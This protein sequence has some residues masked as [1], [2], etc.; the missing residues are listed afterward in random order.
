MAL[1]LAMG[2]ADVWAGEAIGEAVEG[3]GEFVAEKPE[4]IGNGDGKIWVIPSLSSPSVKNGGRLKIQAVVKAAAGVRSVT[5][6]VMDGERVVD[7]VALSAGAESGI[8]NSELRITK[9]E[10]VQAGGFAPVGIWEA[11]W[12][13]RGLEE[14]YY[15]VRLRVADSAGHVF[16]DTSLKF[17]DPVAGVTEVGTTD[18]LNT[19]AHHVGDAVGAGDEILLSC[20]VLDPTNRFIYGGGAEFIVKIAIGSGDGTPKRIGSLALPLDTRILFCGVLDE[21]G[22]SIYFGTSASPGKVVKVSIAD[23]ELLPTLTG[24]LTLDPGEDELWTA[25]IDPARGF[26]CFGTGT[27]P[28]RVVKVSLGAA[29]APPTR[30][31]SLILNAGEENLASVVHVIGQNC[32]L[33]G[34][35]R[36]GFG[37]NPGRIVKVNLGEGDDLPTRVGA[38][39]LNTNEKMLRSAVLAASSDYALFGSAGNP[40]SV[41]KVAVG[42]AGEAPTRV[43]ALKFASES[44]YAMSCGT[45]EPSSGYALFNDNDGKVVK[46]DFGDGSTT[47]ILVSTSP[48]AI[49]PISDAP[50]DVVAD[51][52]AN[53]AYFSQSHTGG[54]Y[55]QPFDLGLTA[56]AASFVEKHPLSYS[57]GQYY[58]LFIDTSHEH[59]YA[60]CNTRFIKYSLGAN[61]EAP[62]RISD[63][64]VVL[65][66]HDEWIHTG[67]IDFDSGIAYAALTSG[68]IVKIALGVGNEQPQV[69][70]TVYSRFELEG[71][72]RSI[73]FDFEQ[74][75]AY[76][77][78]GRF[79]D[80]ILLDGAS[81]L[82][83]VVETLELDNTY[84]FVEGGVMDEDNGYLYF[85]SRLG[86]NPPNPSRIVKIA[87]GEGANAPN[88]VDTL[89]LGLLSI[90]SGSIDKEYGYGYFGTYTNDFRRRLLKVHLGDGNAVPTITATL[91]LPAHPESGE[92]EEIVSGEIDSM[93][94]RGYFIVGYGALAVIALHEEASSLEFLE[95]AHE[96]EAN[97]N[98]DSLR[99][100]P[101]IRTM[102]T[103]GRGGSSLMISKHVFSQFNV[104]KGSE[105]TLLEHADVMNAS[106]YSHTASGNARLAIYDNAEPRKLL[107]QSGVVTNNVANGWLNVSINSGS[108]VSLVLAPG[109]YWLAWQVDTTDDVPSY[110]PG[111][112][113]DG[114][115]MRQAFGPAPS[116]IDPADATVTSEK[117]SMYL[118]YEVEPVDA[119]N[120]IS[121][122][123]PAQMGT[124]HDVPV[125]V[126]MM[127]VGNT[128]WSA[129]EGYALGVV[130]D[131]C[132]MI[133]GGRIGILNGETVEPGESYTF[134]VMLD[135]PVAPGACGLEF[136]MVRDVEVGPVVGESKSDPARAV[137]EPIF[138]G[139]VLSVNPNVVAAVNGAQFVS[140]TIPAKMSPGQTTTYTVQMKNTGNTAWFPGSNHSLAVLDGAC[141][142]FAPGNRLTVRA[143][144]SVMPGQN[145][146]FFVHLTAPGDVGPCGIQFRMVEEFV[147]FFGDTVSAEVNV[148]V[149]ANAVG[150]GSWERYE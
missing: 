48:T 97:F 61:D 79:V 105:I 5:A 38:L 101:E 98:F 108:P 10:G 74:G 113:G 90:K 103:G 89:E 131:T 66:D 54:S 42:A 59:A 45:L 130:S 71:N 115:Y 2:E 58:Q 92:I 121:N 21:P 112:A 148:E 128:T 147:E 37:S 24:I 109:D 137:T 57:D 99:L 20:L 143:G 86:I 125:R 135:V 6:E 142:G 114:F 65:P 3:V 124:G 39:E 14:K 150:T 69:L 12:T 78:V 32:A 84:R 53:K 33:F 102:L 23:P 91:D 17:S 56:E 31:G 50:K 63:I 70:G 11:E 1:S 100:A 119:A 116:V 52:F 94:D 60:F 27:N 36:T 111:E 4:P 46:V 35:D 25:V 80:K 15:T 40:S 83:E 34:T 8:T 82:P 122:N 95:Y 75:Y 77:G 9:K 93:T 18:Y 68:G 145:Y 126:V 28:G 149:P 123:I 7:T 55:V 62:V 16:E 107:W 22:E 144:E 29:D 85:P 87:M 51:V 26:A 30:L 72:P 110:I 64:E 133:N 19:T 140:E 76:L 43:S 139:P 44:P 73:A 132:D 120:I 118:T 49:Q 13:A 138:F 81:N 136:Q 41:V 47:P 129:A 67:G 106:F 134:E 96:I 146:S 141:M 88:Y 127:N 117:W 104:L